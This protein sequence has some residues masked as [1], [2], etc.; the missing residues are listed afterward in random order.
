MQTILTCGEMKELD[1][2]TI[3]K[4]GVPS[5]VLMERAALSVYEEI[6][7]R[8]S[9]GA[10]L[11]V[12]GSGNNGG[13]G[14]AVARL[15]YHSGFNV[16]IYMAGD[17]AHYTEETARQVKIAQNYGI[18]FV[19]GIED[20]YDIIV[21]AL[22]GVGLSREVRGKYADLIEDINCE[23]AF[24]VAI[25]IPSGINGDTGQVMGIAVKCDLTVTFAYR[26]A[27]HLLYPG[28]V[29]CGETVCADIGIYASSSLPYT[30]SFERDDLRYYFRR[31]PAGN[32]SDF[33][34]VLCVTGSKG[35]CGASY[36][37][38]AGA[39]KAGAGMV[40]IRTT[41]ENRIPLQTLLPE[42]MLSTAEGEAED[43][44]V[45]D[46]CDTVVLGCGL[47]TTEAAAMRV[48]WYLKA[49][50][51][52]HKP[53][54]IDADALNLISKNEDMQEYLGSHTVLTPH[55]GEMSRLSGYTVE[56]IKNDPI[57]T[58]FSFA[59][60]T[61]AVVVQKDACTVTA[62]PDNWVYLNSSGN[63]GMGTAGAGDVLAGIIGGILAA[64]SK[65]SPYSDLCKAAAA[66]VYLHGLAGDEAAAEKGQASM[67]ATDIIEGLSQVLRDL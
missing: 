59:E 12:C 66:G 41:E 35:M 33:G 5:A 54:V 3:E 20:E 27:G 13:D 60:K 53:L 23:T 10:V 50:R 21:D 67:T 24:K 43:R 14:V 29:Y 18:P 19:K 1:S 8:F 37:S 25:D 6:V 61:G 31:D 46:W 42:A 26:K 52:N 9:E 55:P 56:E 40:M 16:A 30:T 63:C 51:E 4:I 2:Q 38:A 22:F 39:L 65:R 32:K 57:L 58:A 45:F 44:R 62:S 49:C 36:M 11:C 48:R 15:L 7:S 28:R 17:P 47:G 34:K 64:L